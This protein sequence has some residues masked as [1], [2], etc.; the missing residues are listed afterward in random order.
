MDNTII[1]QGSFTSDAAAHYIVL[2]SDVDWIRVYNLTAADGATNGD[3]FEYYWQR[4]MTDGRGMFWYHPA[5]DQTVAVDQIAA[6]GGFYYV[7]SSDTD[8]SAAVAVTGVSNATQPVITTG[9]TA[10]L[11]NGDI[12]RLS[13]VTAAESLGGWDFA[14]NTVVLNTSFTMAYAMANAAGAAGTAGYWRRIPYDPIFYPRWRYIVNITAANP[15]VI[16]TSVPHGYTVGQKIRVSLPDANFGMTQIHNNEGIVTAVTAS[17][18]TTNI[19][20]SGYTAFAFALPAVVPFTMP[21][22]V[23]IGMDTGTAISGAV[24]LL[25]DGTNNTAYIGMRLMPGVQG[26]AGDT[27]DVIYWVAGKSFSNL[28]E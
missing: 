2:R 26:P 27:N 5:A 18:I 15:A 7:D 19:D 16:T 28:A 8:P 4:G 3:G 9:S 13:D 23:P 21:R 1:Q 6:G 20:A 10:G 22:V 17:T 11:A 12:V 14:I 24:D 25:A